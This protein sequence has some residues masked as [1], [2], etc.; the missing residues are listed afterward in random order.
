[1]GVTVTQQYI[2]GEFS[3]LISTLDP[4]PGGWL[5]RAVHALRS[6]VES[7]PPGA[8]PALAAEA[9]TLADMIC[10]A[11]LEQGDTAAFARH[12]AAGALLYEFAVSA[13][14]LP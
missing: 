7:A 5:A 4:G 9:A 10:W 8:L 6:R 14:L 13:N 3:A 12:A 1:L 2:V 11:M